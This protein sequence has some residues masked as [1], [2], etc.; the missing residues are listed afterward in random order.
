M[1]RTLITSA[2]TMAVLGLG[3]AQASPFQDTAWVI[4]STPVYESV[5]TPQRDCWSEQVGYERPRSRDYTGAVIGGIAGGLLGNTIGKGSGR[6]VATAIGAATG[7]MVGDNLSNDGYDYR[8]PARPRHEQRCRTVDNWSR[9]LTGYNVTY[10]YQGH[11][12][13]DFLPY[14]P[15]RTVKVNVKVSLAERY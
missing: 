15:G 5:N 7:A 1:K 13:T 3:S 12:Y 2:L 14:D 9:Q 4:S 11:D 6:S 10:R 8:A